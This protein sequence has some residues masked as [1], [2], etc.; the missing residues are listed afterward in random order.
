M[1][2]LHVNVI[3]DEVLESFGEV[4]ELYPPALSYIR[5]VDEVIQLASLGIFDF[6]DGEK[7]REVAVKS[8]PLLAQISA[9]GINSK[10][11]QGLL[12]LYFKA[13]YRAREEPD[14]ASARSKFLEKNI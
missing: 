7:A 1:R 11:A 12:N 14:V 10:F 8:V 3:D 2:D 5:K 6:D 13:Y 9:N 4:H